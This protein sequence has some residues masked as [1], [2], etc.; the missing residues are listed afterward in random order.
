V[1]PAPP[2]HYTNARECEVVYAPCPSTSCSNGCSQNKSLPPARAT[3]SSSCTQPPYHIQSCPWNK[4]LTA[5]AFGEAI[6]GLV[7]ETLLPGVY[8]RPIWPVPCSPG[9]LGATVDNINGQLTALCAGLCPAGYYCP[10]YAT[11]EQIPCTQGHYCPEGASAPLPCKAGS[12][13]T[14]TS[15]TSAAECTP[16]EAGF[17]ASTGSTE[18]TPCAAGTAVNYTGAARCAACLDG[19]FANET[20]TVNCQPCVSC[21]ENMWEAVRCNRVLGAVCQPCS[22][23]NP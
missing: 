11:T 10:A 22:N 3:N 12:Y 1:L 17:Y 20:G 15:L 8:N 4:I 18:Q 14:A 7:L 19:S 21:G 13:S 23:I 16:T 5:N 9:L 2:G 6:L